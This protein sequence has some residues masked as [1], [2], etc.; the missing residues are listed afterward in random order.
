MTLS[1]ILVILTLVFSYNAL[2]GPA[3]VASM[4]CFVFTFIICKES[5]GRL[6][7]ITSFF[8]LFFALYTYSPVLT[9]FFAVDTRNLFAQ[10]TTESS[11]SYIALST[12][13][14]YAFSLP[15]IMKIPVRSINK[16][17][18]FKSKKKFTR[19]AFLFV[20]IATLGELLNMYRAGGVGLLKQGK[21][22]YQAKVGELF[23][24]I[25]S[26]FLL[27]VALF[28]LG[29]RL[30]ITYE[31]RY[32]GII[33]SKMFIA[34]IMLLIPILMIYLSLG[35]RSP[36]LGMALAFTM[37][38]TY[39]I[40]IRLINKRILLLLFLGYSS[41]AILFGI[42]GQLKLLFLSGDWGVFKEYVIDNKAYLK[43]YN[44][45][46]NE[47]GASYMNYIKYHQTKERTP[48]LLGLSY[49]EGFL[50]AVPG[51]ILPFE[52]PQSI[53]YRFRD[54]YFSDYKKN[55][56]IAG[57]GF[58]SIMEAEWNFGILGPFF[59]YLFLG[60]LVWMLEFFRNRYRFLFLFPLFYTMI[61]PLTQ[62]FHRSS[63]G[64]YVSYVIL[65]VA[66][67]ISLYLIK[68]LVV[69]RKKSAPINLF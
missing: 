34:N 53:G 25:P 39:F 49:L 68:Y 37:G 62:A 6:N 56:R 21:A 30:Y 63:S 13:A 23:I 58:S 50:I 18:L 15:F 48:L 64:F 51:G 36:L 32:F 22:V 33:K 61:L 16:E 47:F 38:F 66:F 8:L 65:L 12:M 55:S 24:T 59:V 52:K 17:R 10:A 54:L 3:L 5:L 26:T 19:Y 57:T 7:N 28:Y 14:L 41:L 45:A 27:Q 31:G 46:N 9:V 42:R 60:L 67:L 43:Y 44:P 11:C 20:S 40:C 29:L 1:S 69:K 2:L 4:A 35:F